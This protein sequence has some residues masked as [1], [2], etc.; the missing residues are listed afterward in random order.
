[1]NAA[2]PQAY[3]GTPDFLRGLDM[4]DDA[5]NKAIIG[6]IG[7]Y[8]NYQLPDAKGYSAF[9]RSGG[10]GQ[11]GGMHLV[12]FGSVPPICIAQGDGKQASHYCLTSP[13]QPIRP[14]PP[15]S[16]PRKKVK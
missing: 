4:S 2:G 7:D 5:L 16:L 8:D 15:P 11:I 9:S 3:N 6:A 14:P 13:C 12:P 1:M 10:A